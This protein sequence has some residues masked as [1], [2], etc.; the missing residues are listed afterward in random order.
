MVWLG[1]DRK[2]DG[3][4]AVP[5]GPLGTAVLVKMATGSPA[6][7]RGRHW[8]RFLAAG[9]SVSRRKSSHYFR[10]R[11]GSLWSACIRMCKCT[12]FTLDDNTLSGERD[13]SFTAS[14]CQ[15]RNFGENLEGACVA[16]VCN[17]KTRS[18]AQHCAL[19]I[20]KDSISR[21]TSPW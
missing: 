10:R 12:E 14:L 1:E 6:P 11:S 7:S 8:H 16:S 19:P 9:L 13:A 4:A 3:V 21:C 5:V 17:K 18:I 20:T 2:K 15:S